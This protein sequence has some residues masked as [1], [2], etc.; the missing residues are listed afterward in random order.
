[1]ADDETVPVEETNFY[2]HALADAKLAISAEVEA[3]SGVG[4]PGGA[5]TDHVAT[6]GGWECAEANTWVHDVRTRCASL[7]TAFQSALDDVEA[8]WSA[9]PEKV[10]EGNWRGL[11]YRSN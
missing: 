8:E 3:F 4:G 6:N 5:I 1:M 7:V 2:K 9:Q 10:P 11:S